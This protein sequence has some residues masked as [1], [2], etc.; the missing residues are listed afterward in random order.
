MKLVHI[1]DHEGFE[2]RVNNSHRSKNFVRALGIG[3]RESKRGGGVQSSGEIKGR[4]KNS[5][6]TSELWCRVIAQYSA[7]VRRPNLHHNH[8]KEQGG[9]K[10]QT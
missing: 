5:F 1:S 8:R 3:K 2:K 9:G 4:R 6:A 10:A 7:L